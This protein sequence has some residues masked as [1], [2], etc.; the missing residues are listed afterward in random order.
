MKWG[1]F[2][3]TAVSFK[4]SPPLGQLPS[5]SFFGNRAEIWPRVSLNLH[6]HTSPAHTTLSHI[7]KRKFKTGEKRHK[8]HSR[9]GTNR[10]TGNGRSAASDFRGG[11]PA[12]N[13]QFCPRS[14][15]LPI[16][17]RSVR[18]GREGDRRQ[19]NFFAHKSPRGKLLLPLPRKWS[20]RLSGFPLP[21]PP[22]HFPNGF[23]IAAMHPFEKSGKCM[24]G[25][26]GGN[27]GM[28]RDAKVNPLFGTVVTSTGRIFPRVLLLFLSPPSAF[29]PDCSPLFVSLFLRGGMSWFSRSRKDGFP[30][31]IY[32]HTHAHAFG[33]KRERWRT[34][35]HF[36]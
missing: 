34:G 27:G 20:Y 3:V 35:Q 29:H 10:P 2:F 31:S 7:Y 33:T 8:Q 11:Y 6:E 5:S 18:E 21:T 23:R 13:L 36:P 25:F 26:W 15:A 12:R 24:H 14:R 30:G 1:L 32:T 4:K 16:L 17:G 19:Q 28:G 9:N 22:P